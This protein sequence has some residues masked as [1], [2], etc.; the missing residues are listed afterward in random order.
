MRD[1]FSERRLIVP[2]CGEQQ[3]LAVY[4]LLALSRLP[5]GKIDHPPGG[6][7]DLA[8]A[9]ACAVAGALFLGGHEDEGALRAYPSTGEI[10]PPQYLPLPE[11]FVP[12]SLMKAGAV[13][14]HNYV[15]LDGMGRPE[16]LPDGLDGTFDFGF[17]HEGS[18]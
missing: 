15:T 5:N 8:D 6:S 10:P 16:G 3:D 18:Q 12:P 13:L 2:G 4:E 14:E 9:L 1:L 11:G 7:K 17:A